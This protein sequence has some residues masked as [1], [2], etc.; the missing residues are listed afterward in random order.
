M[1]VDV[2][3][4]NIAVLVVDIH[5]G[6]IK[7]VNIVANNSE[8]T[9]KKDKSLGRSEWNAERATDLTFQAMAKTAVKVNP[10][11]IRGIG[12]TGQMHGTVL[13]SLDKNALTPFIGWQDR[14]CDDKMPGSSKSYIDR[15]LELAGKDGF[16]REGCRPA[17]GYM[18]STLFWLKENDA[19]PSRPATACFLPDYVVM[20]LTGFDPVTDPTNAG[21]SGIFDAVSYTHLTLPTKA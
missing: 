9:S 20:R 18:G 12:V 8:I 7:A 2:G 21:S 17:T 11:K 15:M 10:R 13:V 6:K 14:R 1:G 3:T 5:S 19:L 4:T 16:K